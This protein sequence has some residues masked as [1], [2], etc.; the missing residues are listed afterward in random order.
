M[1][2]RADQ[3]DD[4]VGV[5][6]PAR[7]AVLL[8]R[9]GSQLAQRRGTPGAS[10]RGRAPWLRRPTSPPA[11]TCGREVD[12]RDTKGC[13][14][15]AQCRCTATSRTAAH[16]ATSSSTAELA[17]VL[18][19]VAWH[20]GQPPMERLRGFECTE[21]AAGTLQRF[22]ARAWCGRGSPPHGRYGPARARFLSAF[23][24]LH[25]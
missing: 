22:S 14:L 4:A 20:H 6:V 12:E 2:D 25:Y 5:A 21:A 3:M 15:R 8:H 24:C 10:P 23:M 18:L 16:A 7:R 1:S 11:G 17:A 19:D 9:T 13:L